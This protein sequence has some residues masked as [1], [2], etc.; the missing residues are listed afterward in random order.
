[1]D[2]FQGPDAAALLAQRLRKTRRLGQDVATGVE[3]LARKRILKAEDLKSDAVRLREADIADIA[4]I[5]T[6]EIVPG[7]RPAAGLRPPFG[8]TA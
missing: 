1:M 3:E 2:L 5:P 8:A 4:A 7:K 6:H